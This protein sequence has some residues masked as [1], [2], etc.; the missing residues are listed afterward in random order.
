MRRY[1]FAKVAQAVLTLAFVLVFNFFLFRVVPGDPAAL[2]LRGTA[3]FN[4]DNVQELTHEL[5]LDKPLP[6][7]FVIY[8]QDVLTLDLGTSFYL[9]G[10]DVKGVIAGRIWPTFLLVATASLA[11]AAVGLLIGIYGGWRRGGRFDA[12]TFGFTLFA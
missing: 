4:P 1:L 9:G 7:Q 11:S 3:A 6:Q 5:G 2:L 10:R 8:A 12:G